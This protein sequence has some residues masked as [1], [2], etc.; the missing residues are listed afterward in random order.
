MRCCVIGGAGF[1]GSHLVSALRG[2]G[3]DVLV[4][5]RRDRDATTLP[6]GVAYLQ[7]DIRD[8]PFIAGA[9]EGVDELVD[10]AYSSVPKTSFENPIQDI[11]DNLPGSVAL[12]DVASGLN[13][14]KMVFVSS[15]GTVY[16]EALQLPVPET[17]PT[18]PISPYGITKLALEKYAQVYH[19]MRQLP[20]LCVRPSNPFGERQM[21]YVGQGFIATAMASMISGQEIRVFGQQ[22]TIR[23]YIYVEDVAHALVSALDKGVPGESY[24][25]G[26]SVGRSNLE[27]LTEISRVAHA[28]GVQPRITHVEPRSF[29]VAA[30]VLDVEKLRALSGWQPKIDFAEGI[31][32][33]WDWYCSN[34]RCP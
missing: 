7:G 18:N 1:L 14:R 2:T 20:V 33:T 22:G 10:L 8:R 25:I 23:D 27:V 29:D 15:G 16:G 6:P 5:G 34:S 21:P 19:R 3:R 32:R 28:S 12:F 26:S 24:N 17:H 11:V 31:A 4:V 30:N 9:L 13:L